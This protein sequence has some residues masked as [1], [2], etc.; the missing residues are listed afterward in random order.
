MRSGYQRVHATVFLATVACAVWLSGE[1][2]RSSPAMVDEYAHIPA[3]VGS[4]ELGRHFLYRENP[5]FVRMLAALPV[6]LSRPRT[7]YS[8]AA[9]TRR[10][11]WQVGMDFIAA[12]GPRYHVLFVKAR[13]VILLLAV[14]CG[15]MVFVWASENYGGAA[16][17]VCASLWLINPVVLANSA[18]ATVDV[19]SA[20]LGFAATYLF[21]LFLR[22]RTWR[23]AIFV[24]IG[25]GIAEGCKFSLLVL[26]PAWLILAVLARFL[27]T[28]VAG[29]P[30]PPVR[31]FWREL[32]A[33][34]LL[35]ILTLD[36]VYLF[37]QVGKPLGSYDFKS[38]LLSGQ[39]ASELDRIP[40][41]NRFRG[42]WLAEIPVIVPGDY[43]RG[44]DSQKWEEE[45]GL[46]HPSH[47]RLVHGGFWY[48]PLETLA[49]KL[50]VGTLALLIGSTLY[51]ILGSRRLRLAECVALVPVL[52][53]LVL[54]GSQ[55]G[56]NWPARYAL[57]ALPFLCLA[58]GRP[59]QAAWAHP[60]WRWG[61]LACLLWNGA[62]VLGA[63]PHFLSYG[64]ELVGGF[65]GA[66]LAFAGSD[67]D[68][69]QDLYR[70]VRWHAAHPTAR[71]LVVLY[72]GVLNPRDLGIDDAGLPDALLGAGELDPAG[73]SDHPREPFFV[74]ISS[75]FLTGKPARVRSES[76]RNLYAFLSS[77]RLRFE[78]ATARIGQTIYV[79]HVVPT[80]AQVRSNKDILFDDLRSSFRETSHEED[81]EYA[82]P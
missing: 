25:L 77:P 47:G 41:G 61:V 48:S 44:F 35:S 29:G 46:V 72:Y 52:S 32:L 76:G 39:A 38:E 24:G 74:A 9:T 69:G 14:I 12:N 31:L 1:C 19:G 21:W 80:A 10:S 23:R 54:L 56:L 16:G 75:N 57:P 36:A 62:A 42:T 49:Y 20:A 73:A 68:W 65:D 67:F 37:D 45:R 82:L 26:Y 15:L 28:P 30:H 81:L 4:W 11:E 78:N 66:R 71:P 8:E 18:I 55:T 79:F 40:D 27:P 33:I 64:N 70:L 5:P 6:W 60:A 59:I 7:D 51:W 3:G 58:P 63:R 34:Y 22:Q 2:I 53:M 50:P 17:V 13:C 43:V